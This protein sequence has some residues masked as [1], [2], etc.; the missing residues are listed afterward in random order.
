M[1]EVESNHCSVRLRKI[2]PESQNED[3]VLKCQQD[4]EILFFAK[5]NNCRLQLILSD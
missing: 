2:S 5:L 4:W 3:K 1:Q